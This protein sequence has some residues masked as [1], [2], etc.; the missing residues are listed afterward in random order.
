[1]GERNVYIKI[2]T[3]YGM[4]HCIEEK[5]ADPPGGTGAEEEHLKRSGNLPGRQGGEE[6]RLKE[7]TVVY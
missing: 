4:C 2:M 3:P 1:M 7:D 6:R 5:A